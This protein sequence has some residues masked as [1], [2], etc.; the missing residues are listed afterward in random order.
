MFGLCSRAAVRAFNHHYDLAKRLLHVDV[1]HRILPI[2]V[3]DC[4]YERERI[5]L[6]TLNTFG[7]HALTDPSSLNSFDDKVHGAAVYHMRTPREARGQQTDLHQ[8]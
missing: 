8:P 4:V 6:G 1:I 2:H 5:A 3:M 7:E